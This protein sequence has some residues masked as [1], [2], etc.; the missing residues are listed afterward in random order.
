MHNCILESDVLFQIK[1]YE[2]IHDHVIIIIIMLTA[3]IKLVE[4][5]SLY[6]VYKHHASTHTGIQFAIYS[7]TFTGFQ[8]RQK[9]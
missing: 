6:L 3:T 1:V 2:L 4:N 9:P 5:Y 7:P 8:V